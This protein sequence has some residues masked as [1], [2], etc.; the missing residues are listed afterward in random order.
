MI[1]IAAIVVVIYLD[2]R[3]HAA[4]RRRQRDEVRLLASARIVDGPH[5]VRR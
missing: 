5:R 1:L 3:A 2:H 4:A